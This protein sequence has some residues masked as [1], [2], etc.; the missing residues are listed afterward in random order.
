MDQVL[1][2][3]NLTAQGSGL[4]AQT[5]DLDEMMFWAGDQGYISTKKNSS[6]Y[7]FKGSSRPILE[8]GIS[9]TLGLSDAFEFISCSNSSGISI[10]LQSGIS[11]PNGV[12]FFVHRASG[13][14][15]VSVSGVGVIINNSSV[16]ADVEEFGVL[17][18]KETSSNTF[19]LV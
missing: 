11:W 4:V 13:A 18:I 7:S 8:T 14:G 6:I 17:G 2:F 5:P 3:K 10:V 1:V 12:E 15:T 9:R 19:L 16:A